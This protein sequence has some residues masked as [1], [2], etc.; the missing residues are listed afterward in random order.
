[1]AISQDTR[2]QMLS[3]LYRLDS[4]CSFIKAED[5]AVAAGGGGCGTGAGGFKPGN[6]CARGGAGIEEVD[7]HPA[8]KKLKPDPKAIKRMEDHLPTVFGLHKVHNPIDR[9]VPN[10]ELRKRVNAG[11]KELFEQSQVRIRIDRDDLIPLLESGRF[12]NQ[13]ETHTSNGALN[14]QHRRSTEKE[15]LGVGTRVVPANRPIYGYLADAEAGPKLDTITVRHYGG[16]VVDLK[17]SVKDRA[18]ITLN[19]SLDEFTV[20]TPLKNPDCVSMSVHSFQLPPAYVKHTTKVEPYIEVQMHGGVPVTDIQKVHL[21]HT[22]ASDIQA[23]L[24]EHLDRYGIPWEI[25][26][27]WK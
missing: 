11:L 14:I 22:E 4:I 7:L 25:F 15:R 21:P 16:V 10:E 19:D 3:S 20:A 8:L 13:F 9:S 27:E 18:T 6:T 1:M 23:N 26:D 12:K 17:P 2:Q 5:A 24:I